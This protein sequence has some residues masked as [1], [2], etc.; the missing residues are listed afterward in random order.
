MQLCVLFAQF[1][2][3]AQSCP[4]LCNPMDS[5]TPGLPVYH[6]LLEFTQTHVHSVS[7]VIQPS[8]PL[9]SPS[10][11]TFKLLSRVQLFATPWTVAYQAPLSMRILQAI[12]LEWVAIPFSRESSWPRDWIYVSCIAGKFFTIWAT[13]EA[14]GVCVCVC[15]L[16]A[17]SC[18][19]LCDKMYLVVHQ[20]DCITSC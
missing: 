16:V 8:H 17:Q 9:S 7:D 15:V 2:S 18:P 13:R 11:P 19:T 20:I 14:Q 3:V 4:T 1:S 6:Q 10:P 12:I 5:S